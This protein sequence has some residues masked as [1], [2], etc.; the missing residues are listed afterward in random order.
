[1]RR[2]EKG[3]GADGEERERS[4]INGGVGRGCAEHFTSAVTITGHMQYLHV[5]AS[6]LKQNLWDNKL[7]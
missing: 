2:W 1:V 6:F 5:Q 7:K 3:E 4:I